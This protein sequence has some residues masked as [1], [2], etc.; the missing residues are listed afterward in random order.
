MESYMETM[1]REPSEICE[2]YFT[3]NFSNS[4]WFAY[5]T[6]IGADED[7]ANFLANEMKAQED[8]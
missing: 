4:D 6:S 2:A 5:F 1:R 7:L 3:A 8:I